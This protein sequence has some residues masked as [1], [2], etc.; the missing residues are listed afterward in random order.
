MIL[1]SPRNEELEKK[2]E[3]MYPG[4]WQY[5]H[6]CQAYTIEAPECQAAGLQQLAEDYG[7]TIQRPKQTRLEEK[8]W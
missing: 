3:Q 2:I 4:K 1:D 6:S 8:E 7:I 5:M